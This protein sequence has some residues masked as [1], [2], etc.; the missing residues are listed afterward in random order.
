M[1]RANLLKYTKLLLNFRSRS[2]MVALRVYKALDLEYGIEFEPL[3]GLCFFCFFFTPAPHAPPNGPVLVVLPSGFCS[4]L[5][6]ILQRF[7]SC[8]CIY[9]EAVVASRVVARVR[10]HDSAFQ[11]MH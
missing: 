2:A 1:L 6:F 5:G 11:Y 7:G 9:V 8:V 4:L 10:G 3:G